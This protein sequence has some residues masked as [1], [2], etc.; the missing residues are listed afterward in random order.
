MGRKADPAEKGGRH[1]SYTII[2]MGTC[3]PD[4][5]VCGMAETGAKWHPGMDCHYQC[6]ADLDREVAGMKKGKAAKGQLSLFC[7]PVNPGRHVWEGWTVRDFI[8][9][10]APQVRMIMEGKS[11]F[12]PF[13]NREQLSKW[14]GE[15]Q[16]YYKKPVPEVV[17]YF[18]EKYEIF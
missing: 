1:V 11:I 6:G 12:K 14:C 17:A 16:P 3:Y 9:D 15:N 7:E 2:G 4:H 5:A 8:E 18:A 10:L 13:R